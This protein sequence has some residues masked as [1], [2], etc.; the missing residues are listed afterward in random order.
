ME[1]DRC[2]YKNTFHHLYIR[3]ANKETIFFDR[4]DYLFFL[5]R[6]RL[7]K[8]K[9]Q[10]QILCYCLLP[11]HFHLF[12]K[13]LTDEMPIGKFISDLTNSYTKSIN[14]KY[15]RSGVLFQGRTRN[16]LIYRQEYFIWLCKYI[17]LNPIKAKLVV[18]IEDWEFSPAKD[19]FEIR[20]GTLVDKNEI[21]SNFSSKEEFIDFIM[22][23]IEKYEDSKFK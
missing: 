7:F 10:I 22:D 14:K 11:N 5:R 16:K 20:T 8:Q 21:M 6:L 15:K 23:P 2:F 1:K 13:Q 9:Y 3:G 17:L 12:V 4:E 18:N 19:Y